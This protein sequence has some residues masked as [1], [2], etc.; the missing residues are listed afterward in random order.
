MAIQWSVP[1]WMWPLLLVV[2]AGA[3]VWTIAVYGRTQPAPGR[4]LRRVL[5]TLRGAALG[6]LVLAVAGPVVSCLGRHRVPAELVVTV[7]DSGSLA[8]TDAAPDSL[9]PSRWRRALAEAAAIDS[10][11]A[12]RHPEVRREFLRG[13]GLQALRTFS[14]RDPQTPPPAA[15]GT[16]LTALA[17]RLRERIAGRPVRAVV[18]LSDGAE[19][20]RDT[21]DGRLANAAAALPLEVVG[22]GA[23]TGPP[24]RAVQDVRH[25][26]VAYAG[27]DVVVDFAVEQSALPPGPA[28]PLVV[29][30]SDDRGVVA[31]DTLASRDAVVPAQ[32]TFRPRGEGLQALRLAVSP[33]VAE[34]Y[35][36]NNRATLAVDVRRDRARVL[37]VAAVPG[38]DVRFLAQ[39]AARERRLALTVA[40][41][42]AGGLVLADS[43]R[44]W[45]P[46]A[47]AAGWRHWDAVV[48]TGWTGAAA[49]LDWAVLGEAVD[50]GLG[51]L[52]LPSATA[53]PA[54]DAAVAGPPGAL[55]ALL[56]VD[57]VPWRWDPGPRFAAVAAGGPGHAV[58]EGVIDPRGGPGLGQLPPWR[59]VAQ[60]AA[61][62]NATVLLEAAP[63]GQ[64]PGSENRVPALVVAARGKGRV[65]WFGARQVWEWAFWE[66][67]GGVASG[68]GQPARRVLRNLLVWLAGGAGQAGLEFAT[69]P[70]VYQEGQP[71]RL[72]ARWLDLRGEPVTDR[73]PSLELRA[74]GPGADTTAVRTFAL[75]P[76]PGEPGASEVELPP[77]APGR[78]AVRLAGPGQPPVAGARAELVVTD[79][80]IERTQVRQDRAR[81]EQLA[82]RA[83]GGYTDLADDAAVA[84]LHERLLGLDWRGAEDQRR[85][86]FDLWSGWPFLGLVVVLLGTEWFL[87]RRHGLL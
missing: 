13:N 26:P 67:P 43:L 33:L 36:E 8:L 81:L 44:P 56:P 14:P 55:A 16:S 70:G 62:A 24:D 7:E 54:G 68:E 19:T 31:A 42:A 85:R 84:A 60:V 59:Q 40:Y 41:P 65:A 23:V 1:V 30:L 29:T 20:V 3:V 57:P 15:H 46:P 11:F 10:L 48:L 74:A 64:G 79:T 34:R 17:R 66:L 4:R 12:T 52:V 5:V 61:R 72:G 39:A 53:T 49:R 87:R 45:Q 50:E 73:V 37:V 38:W 63:A 83:A 76:T 86:R 80:S 78:Y 58:L 28:A 71:I 35:L 22:V 2:A 32:L 9:A 51:L 75:A 18:L 69:R 82:A 25:P 27:D 21:D 47:T 77:Q 6:L